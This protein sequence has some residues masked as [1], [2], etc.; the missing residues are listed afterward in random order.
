VFD[1][2]TLATYLHFGHLPRVDT[3]LRTRPWS[4][5]SGSAIRSARTVDHRATLLAGTH[6]FRAAVRAEL[7]ARTAADRHIVPLSSGIDSRLILGTLV[8]LGLREHIEA[9]TFGVP[10]TFD[11]DLGPR[12]ARAAGVRHHAIDLSRIDLTGERMR[13]AW[14]AHPWTFPHEI[15]CNHLVFEHF[16]REA[17]YWSGSQANVIAG[18]HADLV[19]PDWPSACRLFADKKRFTRSIDLTPPGFRPESALPDEPLLPGSALNGF[20]QLF[21][22]VRNPSRN[23]PAQVPAGH[24]IRMP[25]LRPGWVEL[26]LTL[27]RSVLRG[28]RLYREIAAAAEPELFALPTKTTHG[29]PLRAPAWRVQIQRARLKAARLRARHFPSRTAGPN[30]R[31]NYVDFDRELRDPTPL[32]HFVESSLRG[33]ADAGVVPWLDPMALLARHQRA[34]AN[35]GDA[36]TL[37]A[38][39]RLASTPQTV[40][41][42]EA[43][44]GTLSTG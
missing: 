16:G 1:T 24:D 18:E 8:R 40:G 4:N 34:Q 7:E 30:P 33:L 13:R 23:D 39:A 3:Q 26:L 42:G 29:L 19:A 25:F 14:R 11:F 17:T 38:T 12:V 43:A 36:L 22:A 6:T 10:G 32:R 31:L 27:P 37:L 41:S 28:G 2:A 15:A 44:A 35:L 5:L 9:V 20:Q 21:I